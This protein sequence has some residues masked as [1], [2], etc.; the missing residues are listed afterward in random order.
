[1]VGAEERQALPT[2]PPRLPPLPLSPPGRS[3]DL[4]CVGGVWG[5]GWNREGRAEGSSGVP[6]RGLRGLWPQYLRKQN[7]KK[8]NEKIP[9][10]LTN[11]SLAG[12]W[13]VAWLVAL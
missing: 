7:P 4:P 5:E 13:L 2:D 9:P 11:L 3:S 8:G 1:M 10:T 12:F 6:F